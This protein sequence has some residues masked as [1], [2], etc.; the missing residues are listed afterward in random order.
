LIW[1]NI[2]SPLLA[3]A[4][5]HRDPKSGAFHHPQKASLEILHEMVALKQAKAKRLDAPFICCASAIGR[6]TI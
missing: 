3:D 4:H 1:P 5:N 2:F 6:R